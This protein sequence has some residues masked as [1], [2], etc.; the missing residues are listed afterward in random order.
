MEG[1]VGSQTSCIPNCRQGLTPILQ[2]GLGPTVSGHRY[3]L[4]GVDLLACEVYKDFSLLQR[5]L[6]VLGL[7]PR[8]I[9]VIHIC[10]GLYLGH[11]GLNSSSPHGHQDIEQDDA[12]RAALKDAIGRVIFLAQRRVDPEPR[13]HTLAWYMP[14]KARMTLGAAPMRCATCI[15][16]C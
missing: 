3:R 11:A 14:S 6:D 12:Q 4:L 1:Q 10:L 8:H 16:M 15:T 5:L 13:A 9:G 7:G 2:P